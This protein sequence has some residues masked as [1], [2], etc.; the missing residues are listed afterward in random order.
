MRRRS[1]SCRAEIG[2]T[3]ARTRSGQPYGYRTPD[4]DRILASIEALKRTVAG[5]YDVKKSHARGGLH[6]LPT[7]GPG[8]AHITTKGY[9][10]YRRLNTPGFEGRQ[11]RLRTATARG[12]RSSR[13]PVVLRTAPGS[14]SRTP[15]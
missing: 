15:P 12:A 8:H 11:H 9:S 7:A 3:A 4:H 13:R 2:E 5:R 6:A 14:T 10:R 1:G